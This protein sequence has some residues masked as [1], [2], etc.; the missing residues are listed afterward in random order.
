MVE[1][2]KQRS[3]Y[4]GGTFDTDLGKGFRRTGA[5]LVKQDLLYHL[6]T[7]RGERVMMPE[8][9]TDIQDMVFEPNDP[10]TQD[11]I[12]S[13]IQAVI[14]HDPRVELIRS[15]IS[16]DEDNYKITIEILLRFIELEIVDTLNLDIVTN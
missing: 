7:R 5:D 11:R 10:I 9:G 13:E 16:V 12:N 4:V 3:V 2:V 15:V 8:F 14:D 6:F 1:I